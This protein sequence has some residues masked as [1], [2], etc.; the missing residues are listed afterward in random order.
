MADE[1]MVDRLRAGEGAARHELFVR[2]Q[3]KLRPYFR[4]RL[5]GHDDVD[6][7]VSEVVVRALEGIR[8]GQQPQVLDAWLT[9]IAW[10]LL[11]D[12][13]TELDQRDDRDVPDDLADDV[14]IAELMGRAELLS[15]LTA[16]LDGLKPALRNVMTTHLRLT[17]QRDHLVVGGELAVALDIPKSQAD[18]Q[19][20]R[21]RQATYEAIASYVLTRVG[22]RHCTALDA[23]AAG[24]F[25]PKTSAAVIKH[26]TGCAA[27]E[28]HLRE[29]RDYSRWAL[30]P[31]LAG[32][33]DDEE[34]KRTII[35]FFSRG[36]DFA[37]GRTSVLGSITTRVA[38]VPG[39]DTV[40]RLVQENP[41][42]AR[43]LAAGTGLVAAAVIALLAANDDSPRGDVA[44]PDPTG[45]SSGTTTS[46]TTGQPVATTAT[47]TPPRGAPLVAVV[48]RAPTSTRT[49]AAEPAAVPVR[50]TTTTSTTSTPPPAPP[51]RW[52]FARIDQN[53]APIGQ[54]TP[55]P[56]AWQWGTTSGATVV[57]ESTGVYRVRMPGAASPS[58]IAHVTVTYYQL[59]NP[60]GCVVRDNRSEG[61][62]QVVLVACHERAAAQDLRF[63]VLLAEPGGRSVVRPGDPVRVLG[64]GRYEV[65]LAGSLRGNGYAQVT[66][67][68]PGNVR[69]Q[70]GGVRSTATGV[71][72]AVRCTGESR[73]ALTYTENGPLA[74]STGAYAQTTGTS[75]DL[76]VD[77]TRSHNS[78]GGAMTLQRWGP[79]R[80]VVLMKGIGM[81]GGT[82]QASATETGY[83]HAMNWSSFPA[84]INDVWVTVQCVDDAGR[85]ADLPFGVTA[86][87]PPPA[88]GEQVG[89]LHPKDPGVHGPGDQWG[90]VQMQWPSTPV[91]VP[92]QMHPYW[93]WSTWAGRLG[94]NDSWWSRKV[95]VTREGTGRYLVRMP[96]IGSPQAVPHVTAYSLSADGCVVRGHRADGIDGLVG[97]NCY[98]STA[99]PK[100]V[101]FHLFLGV[102]KSGSVTSEQATRTGIGAYEVMIPAAEAGFAKVTPLGDGPARCGHDG[103]VAT[104]GQVRFRVICDRDTRWRLSHVQGTGLHQ[105]TTAPAA[106]LTATG[107][108]EVVRA[109][110]EVPEIVRTSAGRYQVKYRTLG[111][112]VVWP[113][114][115]VQVTTLG[116][117]RTCTAIGLNSYGVPARNVW[118]TVRCFDQAGLPAD[119]DFG[120][121]YV[122]RP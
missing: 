108:G 89:P 37:V 27:C 20:Q 115:A 64:P 23:L 111:H 88:P 122:R 102:P 56:L 55:V 29:A 48:T 86:M 31:G 4:R 1:D 44:L 57:R 10:N 40:V 112:P 104:G 120:V 43:A 80:Y 52:A 61:A 97:V 5:R 101:P 21:A 54:E 42:V 67:Y 66:P 16:A 106:Y 46:T 60:V 119:S 25:D 38:T 90:Y 34:S 69:C 110:G 35:A 32:L 30:G 91:G 18:R 13:Y 65:D 87:R 71:T 58:A 114:D 79:G 47:T 72:I 63:T 8:N 77:Q 94:E 81:Q 82:V 39:V 26:A 51:A 62:D 113:A 78:T 107:G 17:L 53:T 19:L 84:P 93:Q 116:S 50:P 121:A 100:D 12:R 98:G 41:V 96:G 109:F 76:R 59:P 45:T 75:T 83:C 49:T 14:D 117:A 33:V 3:A 7:L 103:G 70:P 99:L 36:G 6:D 22:R 11:K 85:V 28:S 2:C 73:F 74:G 105:D 118:L 9:G 24:P 68:S 92:T 95:T 15:V